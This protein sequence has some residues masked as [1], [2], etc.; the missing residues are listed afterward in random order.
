MPSETSSFPRTRES[1][2]RKT[3]GLY[4]KKQKPHTVIPAN[5]GIQKRNTTGIYRKNPNPNGLNPRLR[6]NDRILS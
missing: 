1:N 3:T 6:G 4:R 2:N 5:A